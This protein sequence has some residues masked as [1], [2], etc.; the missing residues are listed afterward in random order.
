MLRDLN[1]PE[2]SPRV[3]QDQIAAPERLRAVETLQ[4]NEGGVWHQARRPF[5]QVRVIAR[6]SVD[7]GRNVDPADG[8][9]GRFDSIRVSALPRSHPTPRPVP[10]GMNSPIDERRPEI[11]AEGTLAKRTFG[12][13]GRLAPLVRI[14]SRVFHSA[15]RPP[16]LP[17]ERS[18]WRC[19]AR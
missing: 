5:H 12:F 10:D 14:P 19:P 11:Y 16:F 7:Q 4:A 17:K 15:V 13:R 1:L 8:R 18:P 2:E 3:R 9:L 6:P